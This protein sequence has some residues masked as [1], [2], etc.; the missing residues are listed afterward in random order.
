MSKT[1]VAFYLLAGCYFAAAVVW[2]L[3]FRGYEGWTGGLALPV[4][5]AALGVA[6]ICFRQAMKQEAD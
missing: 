4:A 2:Y 3:T 6:V 5:L 1:A